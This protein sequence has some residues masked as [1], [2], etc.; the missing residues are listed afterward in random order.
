[1][2]NA[3]VDESHT[4]QLA[5]L[6]LR[7]DDPNADDKSKRRKQENI[8]GAVVIE[9]LVD[10]RQ[11]EG[12]LQRVDVV[13]RHSATALTNSQSHEGLFLQPLWRT[14]GHSKVLV[15]ARN[16][17][18]TAAVTIG[19]IGVI[20]ALCLIPYDFTVTADGKLLPEVRQYV[21]VGENGTITE[22]P[23][24]HGEQVAKGQ[25]VARQR[26]DDLDF[27]ETRLRG[28]F[29]KTQEQIR[30][31]RLKRTIVD[32]S[33]MR[34][35]EREELIGEQKQLET[36]LANL[37]EQ[38][39]ILQKMRAKL[40]ITSPLDGIVVTWKADELLE[41]RPVNTGQRLMQI[42][43]PTQN[44][45]LEIDLSESRM[46]HV[47][48]RLNELK[49][50]NPEAQLE[51][52]FILVTHPDTKLTGIIKNI[53]SSAE[54]YGEDGNAVRMEVAFDQEQLRR[55]TPNPSTDLKIGADVKAKIH[56]G[57]AA[58]GYVWFHEVWEFIQSRILF[59]I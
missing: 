38:Q 19:V 22:V 20:A 1:A 39:R 41:G 52:T 28:E 13:R 31:I 3:Y 43:D 21:F 42:A 54:V 32:R 34:D 5:V 37:E 12:M 48:K 8:L 44:W 17:P 50:Q 53:H 55:L 33:Q 10:S 9:Q 27:E 49:S 56:C 18:K 51:V 29:A 57:R 7:E 16:L 30:T 4:K 23:V 25:V 46:G 47:Q 58:I 36:Y 35:A 45:E 14:I 40:E 15:A 24:E 26:S 6:P 2:V 59:R 11:P